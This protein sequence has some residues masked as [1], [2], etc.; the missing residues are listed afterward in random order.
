MQG[1]GEHVAGLRHDALGGV[2]QQQ[3][4]VGHFQDALDLAGKVGVAG[5]IDDVDVVIGA[6]AVGVVDR[7]VL[8]QDGDSPLAFQGVGIQDALA[9]EFALAELAAL[10]KELI[11]QGG[12]AVVDVGNNSDISNLLSGHETCFRKIGKAVE[13]SGQR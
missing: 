13:E 1:L 9:L 5:R 6:V 10:A 7:A 3:H 12:L 2:H 11:D 4:A 8:G